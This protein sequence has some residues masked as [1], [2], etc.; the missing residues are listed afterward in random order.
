MDTVIVR[1]ELDPAHLDEH[2]AL[3][4]DVF[5]HLRATTPSGVHYG[6]LRSVD[7]MSFTHIGLYDTPE[8]RTIATGSDAFTAFGADVAHRCV[9]AP[10]AVAQTVIEGYDIFN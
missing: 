9:V 7:G 1:Y 10:N 3:I 2:L 5:E 8:A 6:V 4:N